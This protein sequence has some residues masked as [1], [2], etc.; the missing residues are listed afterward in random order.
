MLSI[1]MPKPDEVTLLPAV[2]VALAVMVCE[3]E[4]KIELVI[5][6]LPPVATAVPNMVVPLESYNVT[7]A[8]LSVVPVKVGVVTLVR[9]SE[10]DVPLSLPEANA[11]VTESAGPGC[12]IVNVWIAAVHPLISLTDTVQVPAVKPLTWL[13]P[14][15]VGGA[16]DQ[17]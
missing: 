3:P 5:D 11:I 12:V 17:L 14:L 13:V 7:V 9:L 10:F 6:Q 4:L 1:V 8:P 16:G 2:S 15:P